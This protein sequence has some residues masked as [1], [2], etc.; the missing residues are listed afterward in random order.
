MLF[1]SL[2]DTPEAYGTVINIG[3]VEEVSM[4]ELAEKIISLTNSKSSIRLVPYKEVYSKDF[5]DMPRRVPSTEK[6][7]SLIG[8]APEMT[9]SEILKD[10]VEFHRENAQ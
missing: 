1:R 9:L 8:T 7:R 2:M 5:E 4:S 6:L 10:I 3:G